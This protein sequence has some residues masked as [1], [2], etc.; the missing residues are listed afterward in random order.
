MPVC[1]IDS[2][3]GRMFRSQSDATR[4]LTRIADAPGAASLRPAS[5]GWILRVPMPSSGHAAPPRSRLSRRFNR[6]EKWA[7]LRG[8]TRVGDQLHENTRRFAQR[9]PANHAAGFGARAAWAS[10][11]GQGRACQVTATAR[12]AWSRQ[13]ESRSNR[14]ISRSLPALM[15]I[16]RAD[17]PSL[18]VFCDESVIRFR[19]HILNKVI[20]PC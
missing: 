11:A 4:L 18:R 17:P 9:L 14:R 16:L 6:S 10:L 7:F 1:T 2:A 5:C 19:R 3:K 20:R 12:S 8:M 15:A 13:A